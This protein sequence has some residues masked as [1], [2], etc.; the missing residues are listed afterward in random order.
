MDKGEEAFQYLRSE[1]PRLGD[2]KIK[3]QGTSFW[4][5]KN[6]QTA[7]T[8]QLKSIPI[9]EFHQCYEEWKKRLQRCMASEG[10][11]FEGDNVEL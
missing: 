5:T 4:D 7:L 10:S 11:F 8:D 1:F 2:A 3:P 9:P 6:I